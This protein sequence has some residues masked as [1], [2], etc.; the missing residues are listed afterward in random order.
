[1][2]FSFIF[3]YVTASLDFEKPRV[4]LRS[5]AVPR[6]DVMMI[7]VFLKSTERPCESV[8]RPSSR[9]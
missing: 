4:P 8:R 9:I 7:T 3:S 1:M 5:S 2:T 6:F